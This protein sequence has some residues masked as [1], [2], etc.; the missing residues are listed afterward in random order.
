M[1][2]IST[3]TQ[4]RSYPHAKPYHSAAEL[5]AVAKTGLKDSLNLA[6]AYENLQNAYDIAITIIKNVYVDQK[7]SSIPS[8]SRLKQH[9]VPL[10]VSLE[11]VEIV[12]YDRIQ[13]EHPLIYQAAK[14]LR[15]FLDLTFLIG[16][17]SGLKIDPE[18]HKNIVLNILD[19]LTTL[20]S[21]EVRT[22][23]E[24]RC[25]LATAIVLNDDFIEMKAFALE[26]AES[27]A[28]AV[29]T[30]SP[31]ELAKPMLELAKKSYYLADTSWWTFVFPCHLNSRV[32]FSIEQTVHAQNA[33]K[34]R[35]INPP[36]GQGQATRDSV[37]ALYQ[38]MHKEHLSNYGNYR[39]SA[40]CVLEDLN[41][42][43][44]KILRVSDDDTTLALQILEGVDDFPGVKKFIVIE[45]PKISE[46]LSLVA[47]D[48]PAALN[49]IRRQTYWKVQ[50]RALEVLFNVATHMFAKDAVWQKAITLLFNRQTPVKPNKKVE[51]LYKEGLSFLKQCLTSPERAEFAA[52][53]EW[54]AKYKDEIQKKQAYKDEINRR[55]Q[56]IKDVVSGKKQALEAKPEVRAE[57]TSLFKQAK[58]TFKEAFTKKAEAAK[59]LQEQTSGPQQQGAEE[60]AKTE[61]EL[62]QE[63]KVRTFEANM[64]EG[65]LAFLESEEA[66]LKFLD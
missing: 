65:E 38:K 39:E 11:L 54:E 49:L 10:S 50:Y 62:A 48:L 14:T 53:A 60:G 23:Y 44:G 57:K 22:N 4:P 21:A 59:A 12:H 46:F 8:E 1:S 56:I 3:S 40:F 32:A 42:M 33:F 5:V 2:G 35:T 52:K 37:V 55:A 15:I 17:N 51:K 25:C 7:G 9:G 43:M 45:T 19:V 20:P 28:K 63:L 61:E 66:V 18:T 16:K 13:Q 27:V 41:E 31:G 6:L 24:L 29:A 47:T 64:A 58:E 36:Q 34:M 26:H 30:S